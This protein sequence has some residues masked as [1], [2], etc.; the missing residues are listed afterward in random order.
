MCSYH[1]PAKAKKHS[2]VNHKRVYNYHCYAENEFQWEYFVV[3]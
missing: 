2:R 1:E 3:Q